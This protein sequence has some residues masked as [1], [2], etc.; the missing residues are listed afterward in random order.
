MLASSKSIALLLVAL[1]T[2]TLAACPEAT[3]LLG[4]LTAVEVEL[5]NDTGYTVY[6]NICFDDDDDLLAEWFPS[7]TLNSGALES[8]DLEAFTF[9]CDELGLIL[10]D[11]AEQLGPF[12]ITYV[13]DA[14]QTLV[15]D[16]EYECGDVIRF[17]FVGDGDD[18]GV[19]VSVNGRIVD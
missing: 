10:S 17:R 1:S 3:D 12:W 11:E 15:R 5:V 9:D 8:G 2:L 19:I 6:A 16:D 14:T 13:A 7:E 4:D 18:F